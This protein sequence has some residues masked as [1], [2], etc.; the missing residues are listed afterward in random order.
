MSI[1]AG[2]ITSLTG[3]QPVGMRSLE[4]VGPRYRGCCAG[5]PRYDTAGS[6]GRVFGSYVLVSA[7]GGVDMSAQGCVACC[8]RPCDERHR[9]QSPGVNGG[10]HQ[11]VT[12]PRPVTIWSFQT[13]LSGRRQPAP[14]HYL[15]DL[16]LASVDKTR[17]PHGYGTGSTQPGGPRFEVWP[18]SS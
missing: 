16:S 11:M 12:G 13:G 1:E 17:N 8:Y 7:F 5:H 15:P 6:W 4:R 10:I 14:H 3:R 2:R 9:S 18:A